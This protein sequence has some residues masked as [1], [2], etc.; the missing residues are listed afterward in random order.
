[1]VI[2]ENQN[3][4]NNATNVIKKANKFCK[5]PPRFLKPPD[6]QIIIFKRSIDSFEM[7]ILSLTTYI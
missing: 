5:Q 4:Q 1:M 6:E 7:K 3:I 2:F